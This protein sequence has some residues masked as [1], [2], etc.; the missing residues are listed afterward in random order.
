MTA[1]TFLETSPAVLLEEIQADFERALGRV[2]YPAQLERLLLQLVAYRESLQRMAIQDAAEQS[3]VQYSTGGRLE[4][5]GALVGVARLPASKAAATLRLA[6]PV[7]AA[8]DTA[9]AAGWGAISPGNQVFRLTA[10]AV[11]PAGQLSVNALAEA[12]TAGSAANG[13]AAGGGWTA[14]EGAVTVTS[15]T[16]SSGGADVEDDEAL[17][18]RIL[19]A[20]ARF[21]AAGSAAAYRYH[22]LSASGDIQDVAV[23]SPAPG[24]VGVYVL[25]SDGLPAQATLDRVTAALTADTVRPICD[26]VIV[27]SP[28]R[29]SWTLDAT[30]TLY[31]QTDASQVLATAQ[32]AVDAYAADRRAG[33]GRDLVGAQIVK[34]LMGEGVYKVTLNGWTDRAC[35]PSEWADAGSTTL[36]VAPERADG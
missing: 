33:L 36:H 22:A 30:L 21:S 8:Q 4:C 31:R 29:V 11:I 32:A 10:S 17:R 2:L 14:L 12:E 24:V 18:A 35:A 13:L 6:L 25:T 27:S 15:T 34:A 26:L 23:D 3:L 7:V 28:T 9:F 19:D 1:P 16:T 5:L 20:P